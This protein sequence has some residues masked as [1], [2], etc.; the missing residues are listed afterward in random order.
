MCAERRCG[1][2]GVRVDHSAWN[3]SILSANHHAAIPSEINALR[4][5]HPGEPEVILNNRVL[6]GLA[7]TRGSFVFPVGWDHS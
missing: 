5:A 4:S 6:G 2:M 1:V 7:I 3:I